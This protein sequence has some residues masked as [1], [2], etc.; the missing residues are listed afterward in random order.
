MIYAVRYRLFQNE[1][2]QKLAVLLAGIGAMRLRYDY[3]ISTAEGICTLFCPF[4]NVYSN[5]RAVHSLMIFMLHC[6]V[7]LDATL[8]V[9]IFMFCF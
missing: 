6:T 9:F 7:L 8:V 3:G 5:I 1:G 2:A 4:Y